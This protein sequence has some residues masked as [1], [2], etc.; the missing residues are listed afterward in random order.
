MGG[1]I[2]KNIVRAGAAA[3][4]FGGSEVARE[5]MVVGSHNGVDPNLITAGALASGNT[6]TGVGGV[7]AGTGAAIGAAQ[8][9]GED[10]V[11]KLS[12]P[13]DNTTSEVD[14]AG[15]AKAAA[16]AATSAAD[17]DRRRRGMIANQNRLMRTTPL[18]A[19]LGQLGASNSLSG[20]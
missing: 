13:P 18:G 9:Q 5:A 11:G 17:D 7:G 4:T 16:D 14:G 15:A 1:S 8:K 19:K 12:G 3:A 6:G 20:A 2:V 10:A